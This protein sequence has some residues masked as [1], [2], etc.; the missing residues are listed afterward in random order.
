MVYCTL[1][2]EADRPASR[3]N[4]SG[5]L[6][7]AAFLPAGGGGAFY[8]IQELKRLNHNI[9]GAVLICSGQELDPP[10]LKQLR[11]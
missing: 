8:N 7:P 4:S 5:T 9:T 1:A 11:G 6:P 3:D 10:V 2:L